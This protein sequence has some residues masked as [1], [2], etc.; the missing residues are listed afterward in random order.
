M[1]NQYWACS[2]CNAGGHPLTRAQAFAGAE[3]HLNTAGHL[4]VWGT[5]KAADA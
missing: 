4:T 3:R 2:H 1:K 5:I